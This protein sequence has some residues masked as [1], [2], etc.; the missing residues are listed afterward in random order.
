[1]RTFLAALAIPLLVGVTFAVS[2]V[3]LGPRGPVVALLF[4]AFL[5]SEVGGVTQ[6]VR[7][8]LPAAY[9]RCF[10][11]EQS[12][13]YERLGI[14]PFGRVMRSKLY[15]RLSPNFRLTGGRQGLAALRDTMNDAEGAHAVLFLIVAFVATAAFAIGWANTAAWLMAFNVLL[16]LYPVILQRYNRLRLVRLLNHAR[17]SRQ[18]NGRPVT[19]Q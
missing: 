5:L 12:W 19:A 6:V 8:P 4:N 2:L 11:G 9:F 13:I 18:F 16:N 14:R 3:I 17:Q 15:R 10:R 7:L 1:M